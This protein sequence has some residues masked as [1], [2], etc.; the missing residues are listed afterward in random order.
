MLCESKEKQV[1]IIRL[2]EECKRLY[3]ENKILEKAL[4]L[5]CSEELREIG[6]YN[7]DLDYKKEMSITKQQYLEQA[8]KEV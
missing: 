3:K 7:D 1:T 8:E 4:E 5:A 6:I 2:E